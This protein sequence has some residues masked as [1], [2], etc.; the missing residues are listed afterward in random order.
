MPPYAT[1]SAG[2]GVIEAPVQYQPGE[3]S[4]SGIEFPSSAQYILQE[5]IRALFD[6]IRP[7]RVRLD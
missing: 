5:K 2:V 4:P 3:Q 7:G 1:P 6:E